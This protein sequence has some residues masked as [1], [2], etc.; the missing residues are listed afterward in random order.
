[1]C[2]ATAT[3]LIVINFSNHKSITLYCNESCASLKA[4]L[5]YESLEWK[6]TGKRSTCRE[7]RVGQIVRAAIYCPCTMKASESVSAQ[8]CLTLCNPVDC[9]SPGSSVHGI[10]Q[11]RILEWIAIPLSR[12]SIFSIEGLNLGLPHCRWILYHL[13]HQRSPH[14]PCAEVISLIPTAHE[15]L[16][17]PFYRW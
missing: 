6:A 12:G 1:M 9:S 5:C 15:V 17:S 11:G 8:L 10:L 2:M 13:S 14:L 4:I 7:T 3:K 16:L